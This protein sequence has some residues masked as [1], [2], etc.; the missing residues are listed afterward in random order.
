MSSNVKTGRASLPGWWD[1]EQDVRTQLEHSISEGEFETM[2]KFIQL[3]RTHISVDSIISVDRTSEKH[4]PDGT[5]SEKEN[6]VVCTSAIQSGIEGFT[7][8]SETYTFPVD[9]KEGQA[10]LHWMEGETEV[11]VPYEQPESQLELVAAA[12]VHDDDYDAF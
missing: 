11:L 4:F 2:K 12:S 9:S 5:V 8:S 3:N 6:L 1:D 7:S 10:L